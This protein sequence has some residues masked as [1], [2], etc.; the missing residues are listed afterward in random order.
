MQWPCQP[1]SGTLT[2]AVEGERAERVAEGPAVGGDGRCLHGV[3]T[4]GLGPGAS[5]WAR[6][7]R[8]RFAM[9]TAGAAAWFA[10]IHVNG[11]RL[12]GV[13]GS[14][15]PPPNRCLFG[16]RC[17]FGNLSLLTLI[18]VHG[19][20]MLLSSPATISVTRAEEPAELFGPRPRV[21]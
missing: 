10:M 8:S 18:A 6:V 15:D 17:L 19:E 1:S 4:G 12:S 13:K 20:R 9:R 11:W 14:T 5:R 16:D 2:H 3:Q 21:P 7:N